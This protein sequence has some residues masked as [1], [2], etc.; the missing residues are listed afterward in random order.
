MTLDNSGNLSI[1]A[2]STAAKLGVA[3]TG[4]N[5]VGNA[6]G[7]ASFI[8]DTTTARGVFMGYD[9]T[10]QIGT[11]SSSSAGAASNLAFWTYSGSAWGERARIDSSG[12]L[13]VGGTNNARSARLLS[14]KTGDAQ[15]GIR[16]T[17]IATWYESVQSNGDFTIDRDGAEY[18]RIVSA[19]GSLLL[20][21]ITSTY[22]GAKFSVLGD[23]EQRGSIK[24]Y[25]AVRA[26]LASGGTV[27]LWSVPNGNFGTEVSMILYV[28]QRD[29]TGGNLSNNTYQITAFGGAGVSITSLGSASY[30]GSRPFSVTSTSASGGIIITMTNL[31]GGSSTSVTMLAN[32]LVG[33]GAITWG[34]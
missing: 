22:N 16:Y 9:S 21:G 23:S 17:G 25:Q 30:G 26:G 27:T 15:L 24:S 4:F 12:N 20:G 10:G 33:Y 18:L 2:T 13:L 6:Y 11:I 31:S 3:G 8:Q 5:V 34:F 14:E 19:S 1:G 7:V 32:V 29:D 28:S